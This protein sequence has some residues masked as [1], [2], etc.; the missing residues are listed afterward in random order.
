MR[1]SCSSSRCSAWP[2]SCAR[3]PRRPQR[4]AAARSAARRDEPAPQLVVRARPPR[5]VEPEP[6]HHPAVLLL[7]QPGDLVVRAFDGVD[8]EHL[9]RDER[10]HAGPV[11]PGR[12]LVQPETGL[13]PAV[14][15][16]DAAVGAGRGVEGELLA[17]RAFA[18]SI[19]SR[20]LP[21]ITKAV[22]ASATCARGRRALVSPASTF[23]STVSWMYFIEWKGWMWKPSASSPASRHT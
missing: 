11:A 22:V 6:V 4:A 16:E 7:E 14:R 23:G 5:R 17:H 20:F 15:L 10:G 9:V 18:R 8:L 2:P 13:A 19:S 1:S 21:A 12:L 3:R